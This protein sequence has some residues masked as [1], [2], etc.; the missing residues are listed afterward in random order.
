MK[1]NK[2][3]II[4]SVVVALLVVMMFFRREGFKLT[5]EQDTKLK[6]IFDDQKVTP[7]EQAFMRNVIAAT[8]AGS[9]PPQNFQSGVMNIYKKYPKLPSSLGSLFKT[10]ESPRELSCVMANDN[11]EFTCRLP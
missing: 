4:I 5:P 9:T 1:F 11:K 10:A 2:K 8:P 7:D 3:W 6:S